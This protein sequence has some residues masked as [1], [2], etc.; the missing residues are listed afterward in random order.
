MHANC[1]KLK[2]TLVPTYCAV[3][4]LIFDFSR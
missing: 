4:L 1:N 3:V 2:K